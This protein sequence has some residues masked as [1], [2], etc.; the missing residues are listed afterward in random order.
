M[1]DLLDGHCFVVDFNF[2]SYMF[3]KAMSA[4]WL[5]ALFPKKGIARAVP[6]SR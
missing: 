5:R 2:H 1:S 3:G 6:D 4:L